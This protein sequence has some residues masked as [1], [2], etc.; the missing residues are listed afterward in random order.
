MPRTYRVV[1][2]SAPARLQPSYTEDELDAALNHYRLA[3]QSAPPGVTVE[4]IAIDEDD[5]RREII[6]LTVE[7]VPVEDGGR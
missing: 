5:T 3:R 1:Q 6:P 4:L 2:T 7:V